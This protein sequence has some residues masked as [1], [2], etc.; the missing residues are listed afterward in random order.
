MPKKIRV[1]WISQVLAKIQQLNIAVENK[2]YGEM[3]T[4]VRDHVKQIK[5]MNAEA[6]EYYAEMAISR[7]KKMKIK[8]L[9]DGHEEYFNDLSELEEYLQGLKK[10][11]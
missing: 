6:K 8:A 10:K 9:L 1:D 7:I 3:A 5:R 2:N 11:L 4:L